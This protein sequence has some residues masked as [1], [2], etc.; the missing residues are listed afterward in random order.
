M[1]IIATMQT[2]TDTSQ[3]TTAH[4]QPHIGKP[5]QVLRDADDVKQCIATILQTPKGADP[6]RPTFGFDGWQY[7]DWPINQA[8]P[9]LVREILQAL[10]WEPRITIDTVAVD[11]QDTAPYQHL[12]ANIMW[13]WSNDVLGSSITSSITLGGSNEPA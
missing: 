7:I 4:W 6:L 5:G 1:G 10:A 13:H 3:I 12:I 2:P 9:Y 8:R 11:V